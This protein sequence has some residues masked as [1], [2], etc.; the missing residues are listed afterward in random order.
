MTSRGEGCCLHRWGF[1][2]ALLLQL[3]AAKLASAPGR[4]HA[5][6]PLPIHFR[7]HAGLAS[8][9]GGDQT[10]RLG[11][12]S[13][14]YVGDLQLGYSLL[15]WLDVRIGAAAGGFGAPNGTGALLQ[16]QLG[17]AVGW[18]GALLRPWLQLDAAAGF[19]GAVLRPVFRV[20]LG[21]DIRVSDSLTI[22]PVLGYWQLLQHDG[23][24]YSTDARFVWFGVGLG[25]QPAGQRHAVQIRQHT[26]TRERWR[27]RQRQLPREPEN[28]PP[29]E[30]SQE[31]LSLIESTLPSEQHEWLAPV[32]FKYDSDLLEAQGVAML[33]E[34]ARELQKR[35][36]LK[37]LEIRGYADARGNAV[38][39]L[40]LSQRRAHAVLEW[41]VAHGVER[42]RLALAA[43]GAADFVEQ[44]EDEP[45][46]EQNRR[47]VFRVIEADKP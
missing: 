47:V 11:F 46:H 21:L 16:P 41:L 8:M 4:A 36:Q 45:A 23:P 19:T 10:G 33:H 31:L 13:M 20:G 42:E 15:P 30:P 3:L 5:D 38:Y 43:H 25:F 2:G 7:L 6:A 1:F 35:P 14:G 27:T 34:V 29:G 12:S 39:N 40:A 28:G 24:I 44:G 32:L 26:V 22:G 17:A 18:P 37:K 9:L